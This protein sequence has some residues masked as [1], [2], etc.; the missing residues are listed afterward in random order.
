M[1][2]S[3]DREPDTL[4]DVTYYLNLIETGIR[5]QTKSLEAIQGEL[6]ETRKSVDALWGALKLI[7]TL[8][9][10]GLFKLFWG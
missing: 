7:V 3:D 2:D 6:V 5:E 8:M 10:A 9:F 4:E 1:D